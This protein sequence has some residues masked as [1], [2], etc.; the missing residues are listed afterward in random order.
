MLPQ[1]LLAAWGAAINL[2]QRCPLPIFAPLAP[3]VHKQFIAY[4][5]LK[6][7]KYCHSGDL[8]HRDLKPSN[9]LLN[10]ECL[11][12]VGLAFGLGPSPSSSLIL[13]PGP[14]PRPRPRPEP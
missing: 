13:S 12:K 7:L 8:V 2:R 4:Q 11:L 10:E 5:T 9:L 6:A 14:S 1:A 3:Q